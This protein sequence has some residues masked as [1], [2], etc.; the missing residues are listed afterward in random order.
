MFL[1]VFYSIVALVALLVPGFVLR[2][3]KMI[4]KVSV[5]SMV[6][7]LL[8][9]CQPALIMKAFFYIPE[10]IPGKPASP[11]PRS[12]DLLAG[13]GWT[14]LFSVAAGVIFFFLVKLCYLKNKKPDA[15]RVYT[16]GALFGNVGFI[17]IPFIESVLKGQPSLPCALIYAAVFNVSFNVLVWTLGVYV[18]TGDIKTMRPA[19]AVLNPSVSVLIVAL[20]LFFLQV[21][22]EAVFSPAVRIL[23]LLGEMTAPLSMF[24]VG[25]RLA[26]LKFREIFSDRN[27]YLCSG[28]K[29]VATPLAMFLFLWP[30][31]A[32]GVF[33]APGSD[34]YENFG[35]AAILVLLA[36]SA[37]PSA[38]ST[39]AFC[40]KYEGDYNSAVKGFMNSTL[41]SV[42][43]VPLV[44]T[45]LFFL[46]P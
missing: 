38:A 25:I 19:K 46:L 24:I 36:L 40:E 22:L 26:D 21:H 42:A 45:L 13:M 18:I 3:L 12:P 31:R 10:G 29:L 4:Y 28:L 17:G 9:V 44:L 1:N 20:P 27:A 2:K 6:N 35:R 39:I 15:A 32:L 23:T 14:F 37:L 16:F 5:G 30:F 11:D 41:L 7:I 8:Y 34:F 43:A 33:G